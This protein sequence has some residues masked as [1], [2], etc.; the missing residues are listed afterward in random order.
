MIRDYEMSQTS[1]TIGNRLGAACAGIKTA[2]DNRNRNGNFILV[3]PCTSWP[4]MR[5]E[6]DKNMR[7]HPTQGHQG[8]ITLFEYSLLRLKIRQSR[9]E[10]SGLVVP[11]ERKLAPRAQRVYWVRATQ[12]GGFLAATRRAG[13]SFVPSVVAVRLFR[14]TKLH[15]RRL[16]GNKTG[17]QQAYSNSVNRP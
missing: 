6:C 3:H 16:A 5:L 10:E 7:K 12:S 15:S 1:F 2:G 13:A 11:N 14:T 4:I 9:H 17:F 8:L